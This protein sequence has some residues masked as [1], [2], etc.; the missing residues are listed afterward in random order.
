MKVWPIRLIPVFREA[1]YFPLTFTAG[2]QSKSR[3][4][5]YAMSIILDEIK[6]IK[7]EPITE[8]ELNTAKRS[9]IDTFP[10]I[11]ATKAQVAT[12]FAYDEFTG[13]Y[14]KEAD[15]YKKYRAEW[16]R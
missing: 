16:M 6:R 15:Y 3:T 8:E 5:A 1:I 4:V 9:F 14:P 7:V 13:R 10:R 12:T 11:F 2:F